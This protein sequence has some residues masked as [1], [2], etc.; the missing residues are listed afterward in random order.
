MN[1]VKN[2]TSIYFTR[3]IVFVLFFFVFSG[4]TPA[5]ILAQGYLEDQAKEE[6]SLWKIARQFQSSIQQVAQV[7]NVE[8]DQLLSPGQLIKFPK[9]EENHSNSSSVVSTVVHNEQRSDSDSIWDIAQQYRLSQE[10]ISS[11]ND[12]SKPD[13]LSISQLT[14]IPIDNSKKEEAK[15][16]DEQPGISLN[17]DQL[18][19]QGMSTSLEQEFRDLVKEVNYKDKENESLWTITQNYQISLNY[20]SQKIDE[21]LEITANELSTEQ[22][23]GTT[24]SDTQREKPKG[25]IHY[26]QK[27]ET[28]WQISR[29]YQVSVQ[30]ITSANQISESGRLLVGQ[31]LIIPNT[32]SSSISSRSFIWPLNGL[33]TSQFG[34]RTLG[35]RRDYHTGIDIDAQTG[36]LIKA[37]ESGKVSF[38]GYI[39]GYGNVVI[40]DHA[41]GYSTVYAHSSS[42]LVE[43]GQEVT[44][45]EVI[46][47]SGSTGNA[48]GSHLHFEIR[49]NGKP[50]NPLNY[51]P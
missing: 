2:N 30:S 7:N 50:V 47:K 48:T 38:S 36:A 11:V 9:N 39:N 5:N 46:C 34:I 28:L 22:E 10:H 24:A 35:N 19:Y 17:K 18:N 44:K 31:R 29:K 33:V 27:G 51:L 16:E 8:Q 14:S 23:T 26:V 41:G 20:L 15:K 12:L 1:Y 37:A 42:N 25:V 21:K 3:V 45:G 4:G 40:I 13:A 6:D 32:G 43:E 49:E